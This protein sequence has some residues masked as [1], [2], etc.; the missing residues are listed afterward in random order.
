MSRLLCTNHNIGQ[1]FFCGYC[2]HG[3]NKESSLLNRVDDCNKF[4]IKKFFCPTTS[5]NGSRSIPYRKWCQ[6]FS[7]YAQILNLFCTKLKVQKTW[8]RHYMCLNVTYPL[9]LPISS[10]FRTHIVHMNQSLTAV[11][12]LSRNSSKD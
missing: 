9:D 8:F 2:L 1:K 12:A 5:T 3:F 7:S 11:Q 6:C 4:G 10:F